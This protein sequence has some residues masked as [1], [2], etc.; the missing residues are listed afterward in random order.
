[1]VMFLNEVMY[2]SVREEEANAG[3]FE[4]IY[5]SLQLLDLQPSVGNDFHLLLLIRL[6]RYLGFFPNGQYSEGAA[7]FDLQEGTYCATYPTHPFFLDAV[8]TRKF[9]SFADQ[10]NFGLT[11]VRTGWVLSMDADYRVSDALAAE[12]RTLA[13]RTE[14]VVMSAY[15]LD[16]LRISAMQAGITTIS[17][18]TVRF[19]RQD[20]PRLLT[21]TSKAR[22]VVICN[23]TEE[24]GAGEAGAFG[25]GIAVIDGRV[26][27]GV[28]EIGAAGA[29]LGGAGGGAIARDRGVDDGAG[30]DV[31]GA[32]AGDAGPV[33]PGGFASGDRGADGRSEQAGDAGGGVGDAAGVCAPAGGAGVGAGESVG[34]QWR[35]RAVGGDTGVCDP[36]FG[37]GQARGVCGAAGEAD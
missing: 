13:P 24:S 1:M 36:L 31:P 34:F 37:A 30:A 20:H 35:A 14:V 5:S 9:D 21:L 27:E 12:L 3:L 22:R 32:G 28:V 17:P 10:C 18:V 26:V 15:G 16:S 2:R 19:R 8:I 23:D 11:E 6:T 33:G 7:I 4:F 25:E 29:L